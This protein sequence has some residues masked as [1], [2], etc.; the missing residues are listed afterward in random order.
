MRHPLTFRRCSV[1]LSDIVACVRLDAFDVVGFTD[2]ERTGLKLILASILHLC[3][4]DF[5][6]SGEHAVIKDKAALETAAGLLKT[7][8]DEL[9]HVLL[10]FDTVTRGEEIR[11]LYNKDQAY[12]CRDALAKAL[13]ASMF[14]YIVQRVNELLSP[15]LQQLQRS[16]MTSI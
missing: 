7:S 14:G 15:E 1:R 9:E 3:N 5:E 2:D 13:Y 8:A 16:R 11:R 6:S 10:G 4:V 12:D